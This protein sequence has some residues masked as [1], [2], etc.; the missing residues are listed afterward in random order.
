MHVVATA[1]HVDH[2]KSSLVLALTGTDPDRFAEEKRR[3]LTIDLGFAHATLPSGAGISFIDVPGHVRFL[4]NMLAGVGAVDACVFV[5][6]ATEGWKPQ[7]EEH[8]RI[9]EL[10]GVR[11]GIVVLT[12]VDLVDD[13]WLELATMEVADHV[14]GTFL[15][16]APIVPVAA[17]LGRGMD[18]LRDALD[19]LLART[20]LAVDRG[21]ARLW[22]DRVFAA[23]G[24]GTVVTGTLAGGA[25]AVGDQVVVG[26]QQ[27][28]ARVRAIQSLGEQ[29]EQIGPGN[30]VALNLNGVE[31]TDVVRGDAV[32]RPGRWHHTR[33]VDASLRVLDSLDHEV[34]RRGAYVVY[35]GSGEHGVRVRVLGDAAI[36]PGDTGLVRLHLDT[37]VPLLPGDRYVLRESGR[38]ETVGGGE[39]LDVAP[40]RPASKARPDRAVER[41]VAERGWITAEE[42][43]LLTGERR[44]PTVGPWL[45]AP[46]LVEATAERIRQRVADAGELGL[47]VAGLDD[48]ERAVLVTLDDIEQVGG[49]ARPA[50]V[51]DT[52]ADHPI[53]AALATAPFTPPGVDGVDRATLRLLI[54]RGHVVERDGVH[55]AATAIDAA[56]RVAAQ[57]L[58][59]RPDGF[60]MAEFRDAIAATRKHA[61]PLATE[62]DARG[63]TRR[64]GDLRIAGPR[65]PSPE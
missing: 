35:L 64:R 12:K 6:A 2:G 19:G 50:A 39:V 32:V 65:L 28:A 16:G 54:Q 61:V 31:H 18:E 33:R 21:R 58:T 34:T 52:L 62:L 3:G 41:V 7:S 49:R 57:L 20:P 14:A 60:T 11:H 36:A 1:G 51:R 53:L 5:V 47:D 59:T 27:R 10:L 15:D 38:S 63:V 17:T 9:L 42:L 45:A 8:L 24:A 22:V 37:P 43:E 56:A 48:R 46:G 44:E 4:K 40:V 25:L 23:K 26:P 13:E 30:R 55:F 29:R